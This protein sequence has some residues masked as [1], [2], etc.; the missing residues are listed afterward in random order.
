MK[1][2]FIIANQ[3]LHNITE[4]LEEQ[5]GT[6][7]V[8]VITQGNVNLNEEINIAKKVKEIAKAHYGAEFILVPSGL[9]YI[10]TVI[11]NTLQQ[12]T[13]KHPVFL[14]FDKDTGTYLEKNLDPR[15]L[16]FK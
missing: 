16:L 5:F 4:A 14:Q 6:A 11:Y 10:V 12:I 2:V 13:G 8:E 7:I 3:G 9:Q 1:K 15:H